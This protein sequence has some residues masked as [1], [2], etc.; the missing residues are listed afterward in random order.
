MK[1]IIISLA[2]IAAVGAIVVGATTAYF[3]DTETSSGNTFTAGSIDMKVDSKCSS[4]V[5]SN[6][7]CNWE[8]IDL[9]SQKFFDYSDLKPGD[10]GE[11]TISLHVDN[12]DAWAC[13]TVTP[14]KN[15]DMSSKEPELEAGDAQEDSNNLNDG[16]LAQ[17]LTGMIWADVC[18][19]GTAGTARPGDNIYQEDCDKLIGR[20]IAPL[21]PVTLPL[22]DKTGNVFTGVVGQPLTGLQTY[23]IGVS[24]SLPGA[25]GNIVQS[26]S[27]VS[28]IS[29]YTE[30]SKNNP[31]FACVQG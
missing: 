30:Q 11:N 25:T 13:M 12:N 9:T 4:N 23:Y 31:N 14:V 26:D 3:S 7:N 21:A 16:E 22:A 15:D 10:Y 6:S 17:A 1:K 18:D 8:L 29:F 24:W 19:Q 20:G 2:M 27:Y 5:K 28:D